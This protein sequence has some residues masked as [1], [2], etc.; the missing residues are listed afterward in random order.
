MR[1][2]AVVTGASRGIGRATAL[3]LSADGFAIAAVAR[4]REGLEETRE[5]VELAGGSAVSIVA[6]VSD[7]AAAHA[8]VES[9]EA[10]TGAIAVLVNNAG[11]LRAIG[12]MWEVDHE[13]WWSDIH[14][15]LGGAFVWC[16]AAVPRMMARGAGRIVNV[17]S[18][19]A[20][21]PAPYET[22]YACAKAAVISLTEALAASLEGSG[23]T[24]FGVAPGFT[25][26]QLTRHLKESGEGRR[27]LPDVGTSR[28][29]DVD[30]S[31]ELI[32]LLAGGSADAL[33]GRVLHTLDNVD[34]LLGRL[35]E[36]RRD[37]LYVPRLRRL[38]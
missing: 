5:L 6:D 17:T 13:D 32:S 22:A 27:W 9:I 15:S 21:R 7:R 30:D 31:A 28:V 11:S 26:T 29:S 16:Q 37:D 8:A 35:E 2:V 36:I 10:D 12:P 14:S 19:A 33:N 23:I 20:C 24:T 25:P 3:R 1:P 34:E 38:P 18:Y 4:T